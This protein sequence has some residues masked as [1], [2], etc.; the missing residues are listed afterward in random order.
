MTMVQAFKDH[1]TGIGQTFSALMKGKF[2]LFFIPGLIISLVYFY[3][4]YQSS[5]LETL[6]HS[7]DSIP[8]IGSAVSVVVDSVFGIFN[9]IA[10]ETYKFILLIA[11]S[12]L[13]CILSEKFDSYL[14]GTAFEFSFIRL[15]KDFIRMIFIVISALI[16]EYFF[17]AVWWVLQWI[18]PDFIGDTLFFIISSFFIGFSFY[19]YSMERY[20]MSFLSS[21]G[22]GF[23]KLSY[24]ILTGAVFNL[25][26]QIP[27]AGIILAPVLCA[28]ISTAVYILILKRK[29]TQKPM[30]NQ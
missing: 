7:G 4:Q 9:A 11:L 3:F 19:D 20:G 26:M 21:W 17:L 24:M 23:S 15:V 6:A 29:H 30:L 14:S 1:G 16:L 13:N 28:M 8:L 25:I 27:V 10:S 22:L 2:L 5:R 12:P 18:F